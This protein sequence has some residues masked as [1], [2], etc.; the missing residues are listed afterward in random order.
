MDN[1]ENV[2]LK[3]A[4]IK[5]EE[6][7]NEIM[8]HFFN[9]TEYYYELPEEKKTNDS[10]FISDILTKYDGYYPYKTLDALG[11]AISQAF[12]KALVASLFGWMTPKGMK[13]QDIMAT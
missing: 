12:A 7:L 6:S 8:E 10:K 4:T 11:N 3:N 5:Y 1:N 13:E 2:D 9:I